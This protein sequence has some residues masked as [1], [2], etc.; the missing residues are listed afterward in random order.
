MIA[1]L[2]VENLDE[3]RRALNDAI[4][5]F[6]KQGMRAMDR[7]AAELL[8]TE[9]RRRVPVDKGRLK[10][11]IRVVGGR[12]GATVTS[13]SDRF[14]YAIPRHFHSIAPDEYHF[15]A[16]DARRAEVVAVYQ[17][18]VDEALANI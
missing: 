4:D 1:D 2:K 14:P 18:K 6:D 16:L 15:D 13:G 10:R 5:A 9:T 3:L 7:D 17:Q 11:T 8:A 12:E